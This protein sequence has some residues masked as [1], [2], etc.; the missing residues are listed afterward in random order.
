MLIG[1][2]MVT[3]NFLSVNA[4]TQQ[5]NSVSEPFSHYSYINND[6]L[7]FDGDFGS[8]QI[9]SHSDDCF[10]KI[11]YAK[12]KNK[13][14][15]RDA[16]IVNNCSGKVIDTVYN[17]VSGQLKEGDI[18]YPGEEISTGDDGVVE[19]ELLDGSFI[20]MAPNTIINITDGF[21]NA[22][23]VTQRQGNSYYRINKIL[24][25]KAFD[26]ITRKVVLKD[27]GTEFTVSVNDDMDVVK[28]YEGSVEVKLVGTEKI[29]SID[30][31][32]KE[33]D[34][35]TEDYKSGKITMEEYLKKSQEYL[36]LMQGK[37]TDMRKSV[38]VEAGFMVTAADKIS[39]P[40]SIPADDDKWF[41]DSK[42]YK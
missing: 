1:F 9:R 36:A 37:A 13:G 8:L 34:K 22:R 5:F 28:V 29:K 38:M 23:S 15:K 16:K 4:Q 7:L 27:N 6:S 24:G 31:V 26:C 35:L 11:K 3:F 33:S 17:K 21:C 41:E 25:V 14:V 30:E 20:R 39:E 42:F 2:L 40:E 10:V 12:G 32:A 19:V 18:L